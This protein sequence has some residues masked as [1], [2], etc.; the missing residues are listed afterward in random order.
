MGK[1]PTRTLVFGDMADF[2]W[3]NESSAIDSMEEASFNRSDSGSSSIS[4]DSDNHIERAM[5]LGVIIDAEAQP[6]KEKAQPNEN[7]NAKN[8]KTCF[9]CGRVVWIGT[10]DSAPRVVGPCLAYPLETDW[11]LDNAEP[12]CFYC[13]DKEVKMLDALGNEHRAKGA[14]KKDVTTADDSN[15]KKSKKKQGKRNKKKPATNNKKKKRA[16]NKKSANTKKTPMSQDKMIEIVQASQNRSIAA[17]VAEA[18]VTPP[19][20]RKAAV[21]PPAKP[22]AAVTPIDTQDTTNTDSNSNKMRLG[23]VQGS[24]NA[25]LSQARVTHRPRPPIRIPWRVYYVY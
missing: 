24:L 4:C 16:T 5:A 21:T 2:N 6:S 12:Y 13:W 7:S 1:R 14:K 19:A 22:K 25:A 11:Q 20:K 15:K 18:A 8:K 17:A 9:V 23:G 10:K 3:V